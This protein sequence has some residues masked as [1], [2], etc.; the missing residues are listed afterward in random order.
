MQGTGSDEEMGIE[1]RQQLAVEGIVVAAVDVM[2]GAMAASS[3][4]DSSSSSV[5]DVSSP[6]RPSQLKA[7]IRVTTRAMWVDN[8]RLL[9][10]LHKVSSPAVLLHLMSLLYTFPPVAT[11]PACCC[12]F[13][14]PLFCDI[15][16]FCHIIPVTGPLSAVSTLAASRAA[17]AR[18]LILACS[19][20]CLWLCLQLQIPDSSVADAEGQMEMLKLRGTACFRLR[21]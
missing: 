14:D 4:L 10:V 5:A 19:W 17:K 15:T 21:L 13:F 3:P 7:Q 9:E 8:G 20:S 6:M 18:S 2:R 11:T 12:C 1:E 16:L